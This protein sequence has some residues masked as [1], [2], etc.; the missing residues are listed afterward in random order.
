MHRT[1]WALALVGVV[2]L[3]GVMALGGVVAVDVYRNAADEPEPMC[4]ALE[5]RVAGLEAIRWSNG[6]T[7]TAGSWGAVLTDG[8]SMVS[9]PERARLGSAVA[10]DPIGFEAFLRTLPATARPAAQRLHDLLLDETA[11]EQERSTPAVT[12]DLATLGRLSHRV[13]GLAP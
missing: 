10:Q 8:V 11:G 5:T 7:E 9:D 6:I 3:V 2:A 4:L 13:C 12:R 1:W